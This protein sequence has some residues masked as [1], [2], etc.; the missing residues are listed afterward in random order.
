MADS[1]HKCIF[2][3][4]FE[5][6][7]FKQSKK[8]MGVKYV[9]DGINWCFFRPEVDDYASSLS[10]LTQG[11]MEEGERYIHTVAGTKVHLTPLS[12]FCHSYCFLSLF[13]F[14]SYAHM[15]MYLFSTLNMHVS[16]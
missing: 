8:S 1:D 12:S 10:K 2:P 11:M 13:S 14:F 6:V 9:I 16:T 5:D 15:Y 3:V 4:I 7:N